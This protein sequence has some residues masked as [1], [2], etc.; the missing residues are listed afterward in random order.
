M[1]RI[2]GFSR[3]WRRPNNMLP[4]GLENLFI[5]E[6]SRVYRV[7]R[8]LYSRLLFTGEIA[9]TPM[10]TWKNNRRIWRHNVSAPRLRDVTDQVWWRHNAKS[11]CDLPM[12]QAYLVYIIAFDCMVTQWC[13]AVVFNFYSTILDVFPCNHNVKF[14]IDGRIASI[15]LN[16]C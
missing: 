7:V 11:W 13:G 14:S 9:F 2:S 5:D 12:N 6:S 1:G 8:N 10:D 16:I 3:F 15:W 4:D